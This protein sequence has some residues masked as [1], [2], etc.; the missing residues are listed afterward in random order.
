MRAAAAAAAASAGATGSVETA[1]DRYDEEK[2]ALE[3]KEDKAALEL[4]R[5]LAQVYRR[6]HT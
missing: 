1:Q 4:K 2:A 6:T 3:L 5:L